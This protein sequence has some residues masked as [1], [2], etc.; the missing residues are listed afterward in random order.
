LLRFLF[1][2]NR[3]LRIFSP[4][5]SLSDL[6]L[7]QAA[8]VKPHLNGWKPQNGGK[9]CFSEATERASIRIFLTFLLG[10]IL[11]K[12]LVGFKSD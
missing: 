8:K 11:P 2:K 3:E 5:S 4:F 9:D 7:R 10:A 1:K 12:E 6:A